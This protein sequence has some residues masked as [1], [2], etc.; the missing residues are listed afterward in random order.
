MPVNLVNENKNSSCYKCIN[1]PLPKINTLQS[2]DYDL[3]VI[4]RTF[5]Q[6]SQAKTYKLRLLNT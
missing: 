2:T 5:H 6:Y 4:K 3:C 1:K